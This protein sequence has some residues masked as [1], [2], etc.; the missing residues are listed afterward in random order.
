V[1]DC[2]SASLV[3]CLSKAR[4]EIASLETRVL[5]TYRRNERGRL[6]I[7]S[8]AASIQLDVPHRD[9]ERLATCLATFEDCCV[10]TARSAEGSN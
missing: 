7:G 9:R 8:L 10:V 2:L 6:R 3:F 5:G 1:G 4:V